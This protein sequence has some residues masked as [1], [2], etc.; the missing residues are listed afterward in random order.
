MDRVEDI[1]YWVEFL[2]EAI[3]VGET[4]AIIYVLLAYE[5]MILVGT[6][7]P[8]FFAVNLLT[9][10][11]WMTVHILGEM[12]IYE[13]TVVGFVAWIFISWPVIYD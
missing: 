12:I 8:V 9:V 2:F 5:Y 10:F 13:W 7:N 3:A 11:P 6:T 4:L 1:L